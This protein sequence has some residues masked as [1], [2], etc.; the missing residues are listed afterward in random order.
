MH[1]YLYIQNNY[2]QHTHIVCK[3]KLLFWMRLIAIN[4]CTA[5][6]VIRGLGSEVILFLNFMTVCWKSTNF[7]SGLFMRL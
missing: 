1:M 2:T 3:H 5:L 6:I 7:R 4:L